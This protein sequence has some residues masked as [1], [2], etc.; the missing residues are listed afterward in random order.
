MKKEARFVLTA[1]KPEIKQN[2]YGFIRS[3]DPFTGLDDYGCAPEMPIVRTAFDYKKQRPTLFNGSFAYMGLRGHSG[4]YFETLAWM[5]YGGVLREYQEPERGE[6]IIT[7]EPDI[8]HKDR[9]ARREIKSVAGGESLKL[10]DKQMAKYCVIQATK[11][12]PVQLAALGALP[13]SSGAYPNLKFEIFRHSLSGMNAKLGTKSLDEILEALSA[14]GKALMSLPFSLMYH[15]HNLRT[16]HTS[17]YEGDKWEHIT[18]VKSPTLNSILASPEQ[19]IEQLGLNPDDYLITK[20]R[21]PEGMNFNGV[22]IRP[23]PV[24]IIDDKNHQTWL[25]TYLD[26][27]YAGLSMAE[28]ICPVDY[29]TLPLFRQVIALKQEETQ[30]LEER[31]ASQGDLAPESELPMQEKP[32]DDIPF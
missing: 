18:R 25:E 7:C 19:A 30:E 4:R 22:P 23:I 3:P 9:P 16:E 1:P 20:A 11:L 5:I 27:Y 12:S 31:Q 14:S 26:K 21:L 17:R 10:K 6:T 32:K 28:R 2:R 29:P 15:L 13:V 24:I 8:S